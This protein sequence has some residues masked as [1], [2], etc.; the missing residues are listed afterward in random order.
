[1]LMIFNVVGGEKDV[2]H[3]SFISSSDIDNIATA[4]EHLKVLEKARKIALTTVKHLFTKII[5]LYRLYISDELVYYE[6]KKM[7]VSRGGE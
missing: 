7:L 1:M 2:K 5:A 3:F 4:P 6:R